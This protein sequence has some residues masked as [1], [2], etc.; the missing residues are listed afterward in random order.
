MKILV[1]EDDRTIAQVLQLLLMR[2]NYAVDLAADGAT[3]WEMAETYDY[4]LLLLDVVLPKLDGIT[5]C[6]QIRAKGVKSPIL[7]LTGQSGGRQKAT[8][9][10]AGADDYVVKPFDA[11]ELI[12]RVQALLRR[13]SLTPQTILSWGKL[14]LDPIGCKVT[15]DDHLL[16]ITPKEYAILELLLRNPHKVLS[17]SSL[18]NHAWNSLDQPGEDAVRGHIKE[19]RQKLILG[20]APKDLIKTVYRVGYQLNPKYSDFLVTQTDEQPTAPKIAELKVVNQELR[21]TVEEL[22]VEGGELRQQNDQLT[23]HQ[24]VLEAERQRYRDLF[25]FAPDA[26][27]VTELDGVIQEANQAASALLQ[28]PVPQVLGRSLQE[29]IA[30]SDRAQFEAELHQLA[31]LPRRPDWEVM[32]QPAAGVAFPVLVAVT[33]NNNWQQQQVGWRWLLRD[34]RPRKEMEHRLQAAH[35]QLEARVLERTKALRLSQE[36]HQLALDLTQTGWWD[37]DIL[38]D[39]MTWSDRLFQLLGYAPQEVE[40]SVAAWQAHIHP[41][42]QAHTTHAFNDTLER[43]TPGESEYRVVHP[44][45][46][47]HWLL[48]KGQAMFDLESQV[49]R[50]VGI[51]MDISDRKQREAHTAF[52]VEITEDFA[53]LTDADEILQRVGTKLGAY[54]GVTH[55]NFCEVDNEHD[56]ATYLG[57]WQATGTPSLPKRMPLSEYVEPEFRR[58]LELSNPIVSENTDISNL[59]RREEITEIGVLAYITVPFHQAGQCKYLFSVHQP[60][61]RTWHTDEVELVQELAQRLFP[62]LERAHAEATLRAQEQ[63]LRMALSGAQAG[64]WVWDMGTGNL[65]WSAETYLLHGLDPGL[66]VPS[67]EDWCE[68]CLHPDDRDPLLSHMTQ[69]IARKHSEI[70]LEYRILHPQKGVRWLWSLG[71]MHR[72]ATGELRQI[73]GISLDVSDRK[74]AE[75]LLLQTQE[76]IRQQLF[77]IEAIYQ[78]APVGLAVLDRDFQYLRVNQRLADFNRRPL[79]AHVGQSIHTV[80]P[81]LVPQLEPRLKQVL[82]TGDPLLNQITMAVQVIEP[83]T[84]QIWLDHY[85]PL[86]NQEGQIIGINVV[87]QDMTAHQQAQKALQASEQKLR[88]I[89]DS[90]FQLMGLLTPSGIVIDINRTALAVINTDLQAVVGQ[91]FWETPWWPTLEQKQRLQQAIAQ[92]AQG[93][94]IRYESYH[95]WADGTHATIDFSLSPVTDPDGNVVMLVPE[96][97]DITALAELEA[98]HHRAALKIREQAA[99]LDITSDAIFVRDLT[100]KILYWNQGAARLYG[101]QPAAAIGQIAHELLKNDLTQLTT[102][103]ATLLQQGEWRGEITKFTQTGQQLTVE[104]RWTLMR[105]ETGAPQFILSVDT[106]ITEK[107]QLE[108]QFYRAQRLESL[109][110]LAS[111]IAHDLNNVLTPILSISQLLRIQSSQLDANSLELVQ[112]IEDSAKRGASMIRQILA[113][114]RG[115]Q[116]ECTTLNLANVV[117]EVVSVVQ[118]TFTKSIQIRQEVPTEG[119]WSVSA[120]STYL[121]QILMNLC[122]NARD[123]MPKG[124]AITL[125]T[126][127]QVVDETFVQ[128][129]LDAKIGN[130]VRVTVK[131]TGSGIPPA[132]R[133]RIFE[134]FFTT[135]PTGQGTG[136]GLAT[137]LGIVKNYGGFLQVL[138]EPGQGTEIQVYLPAIIAVDAADLPLE[139]AFD[140]NW[141]LVLI[142]DDDPVVQRSTQALL[143]SH[144]YS[145]LVVSSGAAAIEIYQQHVEQIAIVITDIMMPEMDGIELIQHLKQLNPTVKIVAMSGVMSNREAALEAGAQAFVAKPYSV[146]SLLETV[147]TLVSRD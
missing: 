142:V 18:L 138:S 139:E 133:D 120:D 26:Y 34:I 106:D 72:Q 116:G 45:G 104:A 113:F 10:N 11:E 147:Y 12:A 96:G 71:Q 74:Q 140:G 48:V 33:N 4:D 35:D 38:S 123:A 41:I 61:A 30:P 92:A 107:K 9:L 63:L 98:D 128:A 95:I 66:P 6:Q 50:M 91:P 65:I 80:V 17:S 143:D 131:D 83:E 24:Q 99:L 108:S 37:W 79:A 36:Q 64:S 67:F 57:G 27:L 87:V 32:I 78:T 25:E 70:Q 68:H 135:K 73:S 111:G 109:G 100:H 145:T 121:H 119:L 56:E 3:G 28:V 81:T 84:Q 51:A 69:A 102:I 13:A 77:E 62:R 53:Q 126:T 59:T 136:L 85:F 90:T 31:I 110:T 15:Y 21:Q 129:H 8:A 52:L 144:F 7:L 134:P 39:R 125:T 89:F 97:R 118:Q 132:V 112:V 105:D 82:D 40:P 137:V 58:Q 117:A 54:L 55:C 146:E 115:S 88:A 14:A 75:L 20:G 124:G 43:P 5:L 114:T 46:S 94:F 141:Q 2:H 49:V 93:E 29:W 47:I 101:W 103:T 42:D 130:F 22:Q 60:T 127:N 44:D 23:S 1:V 76:T 86:K 19:L 122:I 16:T